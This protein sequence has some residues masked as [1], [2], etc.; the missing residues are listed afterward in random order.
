[1][2]PDE[3]GDFVL[4][5]VVYFPQNG[6]RPWVGTKAARRL[7]TYPKQTVYD[8]KRMLTKKID[9]ESIE[10]LKPNW[11]FEL[12]HTPNGDI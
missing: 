3:D 10:K 1:M 7:Q 9:D 8:S 2:V 6:D 11:P 12:D 4:H 5:S